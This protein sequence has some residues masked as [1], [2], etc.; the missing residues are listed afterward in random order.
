M[1]DSIDCWAACGRQ[2]QFPNLVANEVEAHKLESLSNKETTP[3]WGLQL[4]INIF[5]QQVL[6]QRTSCVA[7]PEIVMK[8]IDHLVSKPCTTMLSCYVQPLEVDELR[9]V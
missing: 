9:L 2:R 7:I 5:S 4:W 6:D 8:C 1:E 3:C